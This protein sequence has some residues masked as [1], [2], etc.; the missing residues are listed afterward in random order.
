MH[1]WVPSTPVA[2]LTLEGGCCLLQLAYRCYSSYACSQ[3]RASIAF[4]CPAC[5][6][7]TRRS[8]HV[9]ANPTHSIN[10][11]QFTSLAW[12]IVLGTSARL[13][14]LADA[15]DWQGLHRALQL[16]LWLVHHV[17]GASTVLATGRSTANLQ[18]KRPKLVW[19]RQVSLKAHGWRFERMAL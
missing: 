9:A 5:H 6:Q 4:I 19:C 8:T 17:P 18:G 10:L 16:L 14:E 2:S 15:G 1:C 13:P 7:P 12:Q 3:P 11:M